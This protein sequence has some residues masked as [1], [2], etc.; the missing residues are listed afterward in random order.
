MANV[1][2]KDVRLTL[3]FKLDSVNADLKSK[4]GL[5]KLNGFNSILEDTISCKR[6]NVEGKSI[7]H[8]KLFND[9]KDES[10]QE[11][12]D[13]MME[14]CFTKFN[15]SELSSLL[16]SIYERQQS[17]KSSQEQVDSSFINTKG[18]IQ[19]SKN[20][21][22]LEDEIRNNKA[23]FGLLLARTNGDKDLKFRLIN[24]LIYE[25]NEKYYTSLMSL[26]DEKILNT[27]EQENNEESTVKL[28]DMYLLQYFKNKTDYDVNYV[29]F[30]LK[31]KNFEL[32]YSAEN[33]IYL[34]EQFDDSEYI[35]K[36][37]I[38]GK[39]IEVIDD[40][41]QDHEEFI[42][43]LLEVKSKLKFTLKNFTPTQQSKNYQLYIDDKKNIGIE[44]K[45][46]PWGD[47]DL[48]THIFALA[49][50]YKSKYKELSEKL[51]S[52]IHS[53]T[54]EEL[55]DKAQELLK[56]QGTYSFENP[57]TYNAYNAFYEKLNIELAQN[58]L[59]K[60]T[61]SMKAS[62]RI[63]Y[64]KVE[65]KKQDKLNKIATW[66][67]VF[68]AMGATPIIIDFIKWIIN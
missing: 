36:D 6:F 66:F 9:L 44:N 12:L 33:L 17:K 14:F 53:C 8:S 26:K 16:Y 38:V 11:F 10:S 13:D 22:E 67:T 28:H 55:E 41:E 64:E 29:A 24:D 7:L 62:L 42:N 40:K 25:E 45:F 61:E 50:A 4:F 46:T 59:E 35:D 58:E 51:A 34:I 37:N 32:E 52:D 23:T 15:K 19:S 2:F 65:K 63:D 30:S 39:Y 60:R 3:F 20:V 56:F 54:Y 5:N 47:K 18:K 21:K 48:K 27:L 68:G 57:T 31:F 43:T 49:L 1:K